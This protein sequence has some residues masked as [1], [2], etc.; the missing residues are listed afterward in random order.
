MFHKR[1]N[2]EKCYLGYSFSVLQA[3][4]YKCDSFDGN[5]GKLL[6]TRTFKVPLL[7]IKDDI[8]S[9]LILCASG[10]LN[11]P[12]RETTKDLFVANYDFTIIIKYVLA[13]M[14][15]QLFKHFEIYRERAGRGGVARYNLNFSL[16]MFGQISFMTFTLS[17]LTPPPKNDNLKECCSNYTGVCVL[18]N[19]TVLQHSFFYC[20]IKE[21][22]WS[23]TFAAPLTN[24]VIYLTYV[25]SGF[26]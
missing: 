16:W 7:C 5:N 9:A 17:R 20:Q 12:K 14:D 25:F 2:P 19:L 23:Y 1:L 6:T 21:K 15:N 8:A 18:I 24:M 10:Q 26:K 4:T 13:I 22:T 3:K 11:S